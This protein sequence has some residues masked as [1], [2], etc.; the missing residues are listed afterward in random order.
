MTQA[1]ESAAGGVL[2]GS[3]QTAQIGFLSYPCACPCSPF[4][5]AGALIAVLCCQ[6]AA[7]PGDRPF[8]S[9]LL[10]RQFSGHLGRHTE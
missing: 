4:R 9:N 5:V 8:S 6:Q 1:G 2:D 3:V 10:G 7:S